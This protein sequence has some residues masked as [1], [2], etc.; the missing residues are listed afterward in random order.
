MT[1]NKVEAT[2]GFIEDMTE[3]TNPIQEVSFDK[4]DTKAQMR[5]YEDDFIQGLIDAA[6]YISDEVQHIEIARGG[7]VYFAFDIRPL[8]VWYETAR[9]NKQC[10]ISRFAHLYS[11]NR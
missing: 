5:V 11:N 4:E 6:S 10:E 8:S 1:D 3:I 7:R 2:V 9:G